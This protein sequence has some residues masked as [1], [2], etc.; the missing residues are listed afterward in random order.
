MSSAAAHGVC[1]RDTSM[2][3]SFSGGELLQKF[4]LAWLGSSIAVMNCDPALT[5]ISP[6]PLSKSIVMMPCFFPDTLKRSC[7][8]NI[9]CDLWLPAWTHDLSSR[10]LEILGISSL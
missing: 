1:R 9:N 5:V 4:S 3:M 10:D 8:S 6:P 2:M 7:N